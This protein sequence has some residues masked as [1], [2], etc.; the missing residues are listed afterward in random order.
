V[1]HKILLIG[2]SSGI[3]LTFHF[4]RLAIALKMMGNEVIVLS[5][6]KEQYA[7]LPNDLDR[8]GIRRYVSDVM[9]NSDIIGVIK[10]AKDLRRVLR[11]EKGFDVI[12]AGGVRH[13]VKVFFATRRLNEKP[14]TF[15]TVGS[16]P[17]SKVGMSVAACSYNWFYDKC[18]ALS[19]YTKKELVKWRVDA[20]KICVIPLF[21]PD[22]EWFDKAKRD[23]IPLELYNIQDVTKPVVF[24]A[25]SH[26]HHKGFQYYLMAASKVLKR[27]DAT[28][29]V[30]GRGPLTNSFKNFAKKL[31]ISKHIVFTGWISNYHMPHILSNVADIC[32]STSLVEQLPSYI[33]EC[34]AAGKPAVAS[35][36][37]GVPEIILNEVNGY[38]VPP[39]DFEGTAGRIMDLLNNPEKAREMGLAGRRMIEEQLNMKSSVLKL[40]NVYEETVRS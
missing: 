9:D 21:A 13:G 2:S 39:H 25:A 27:F 19:N 35:S 36:V 11:E 17:R 14:K 31:G 12:H 33:V 18:V 22:L 4:T 8:S 10:G 16:L 38:L 34:M 32:V 37:G 1:S 5:H 30:G 3:G 6:R 24:Y 15:A 23:K 20:S 29:V 40:L 28:F 7:E 26:F